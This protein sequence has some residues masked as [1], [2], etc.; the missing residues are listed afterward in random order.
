MNTQD[1]PIR[2]DD[3][4]WDRSGPVDAEVA[5]L[6]RLLAPY[7]LRNDRRSTMSPSQPMPAAHGK[8]RARWRRIALASAAVVVMFAIGIGGWYRHR[9]H[10][11]TGQAWQLSAV[12]GQARID[13]RAVTAAAALA[14]GSLLE[15]GD[16]ASVRLRA[17][18]I[19]ELVVGE[20]SRF[21]LVATRSGR[22]R[23]QLQHGSLWAR[24]WAPPGA[25]GVSTPATDVYDLGCEFLL[26]V[27]AAGHGQLTVRSG[28]VQ[29][30]NLHWEVLVPQGARVE[31]RG[32]RMPGTPYDLGASASFIAALHDID[33]QG[34]AVAAD[35]DAVRRLVDAARPQDAITLLSLLMRY[36]QLGDGPVFERLA[37]IMPAGADVTREGF[38][39]RGADAL[40]PW[41]NSLPYP[42]MKRWWMNWP[43]AFG[44][45]ADNEALL[46]ESR[47]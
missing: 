19:G 21:S 28:W 9:L 1:E 44:A 36:P 18:R 42:R 41:W 27:D 35:G 16:G 47:R 11:P 43:D 31:L 38:R 34:H 26:K 17:A 5:R 33:A 40:N 46:D 2:A 14:S 7:A 23:V 13:G 3:Y 24:V 37:Q 15:T 20:D 6:E 25:L 8:R 22:H 29:V 10:W 4:L 39:A 12:S 45:R 32:E 30:D